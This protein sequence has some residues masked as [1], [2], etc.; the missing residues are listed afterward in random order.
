MI[1]VPKPCAL[2]TAKDDAAMMARK[3][4]E[5]DDTINLSES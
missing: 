3:S 2:V 1:L 4:K 5:D